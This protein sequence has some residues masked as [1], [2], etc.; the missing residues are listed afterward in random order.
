[1]AALEKGELHILWQAL[2]FA[3]PC[4]SLGVAV[5]SSSIAHSSS[6]NGNIYAGGD[7]LMVRHS[8]SELHSL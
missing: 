4:Q 8:V 5:A 6:D 1:V 7:S 2:Y 3:L